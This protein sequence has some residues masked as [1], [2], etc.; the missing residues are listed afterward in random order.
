MHNNFA[1][2]G[3]FIVNVLAV[4]LILQNAGLENCRQ[5]LLLTPKNVLVNLMQPLILI[6][7]AGSWD[8]WVII[9]IYPVYNYI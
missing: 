6:G 8:N 7:H 9:Y 4:A 3:S 5:Q 2:R 1:A